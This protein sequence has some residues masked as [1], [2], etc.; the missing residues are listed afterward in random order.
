M[1]NQISIHSCSNGGVASAAG[2]FHRHTRNNSDSGGGLLRSPS[3]GSKV[4][5]YLL[6]QYD[7]DFGRDMQYRDS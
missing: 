1:N 4:T 3:R 7:L 6:V 5:F 2:S